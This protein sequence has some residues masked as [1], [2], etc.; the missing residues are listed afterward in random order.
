MWYVLGAVALVAVI[1]GLVIV[2]LS[3]ALHAAASLEA[4]TRKQVQRLVALAEPCII[5]AMGLAVGFIVVA[6]L[7]AIL[8][9]TDLPL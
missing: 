5:L 7:M 9:I 8:T 6:I 4:D 3:R 2:R 1:E